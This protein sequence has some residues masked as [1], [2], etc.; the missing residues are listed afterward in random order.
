M[1]SETMNQS[2]SAPWRLGLVTDP[3]GHV[4]L[5]AVLADDDDQRTVYVDLL[6]PV[7]ASNAAELDLDRL[8]VLVRGEH[9]ADLRR[10]V[11]HCIDDVRLR[12]RL[13]ELADVTSSHTVVT[14]WTV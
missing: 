8:V 1:A 4:H 12:D 14:P 9:V 5:G 10:L 2:N 13:V 11:V 7:G 6:A 3:R